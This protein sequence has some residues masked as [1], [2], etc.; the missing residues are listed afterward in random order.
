MEVL[1]HEAV[2]RELGNTPGKTGTAP[3]I[4]PLHFRQP[5]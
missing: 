3:S 2:E 5:F 1:H 4:Q